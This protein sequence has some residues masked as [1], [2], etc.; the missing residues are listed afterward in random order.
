MDF[1]LFLLVNAALFIRPGELI[2]A[3]YGWPVYNFIIVANLLVAAPAVLNQL[4]G[5]NLVETPITVCVIGVFVCIVLSL[6]TMFDI[7]GAWNAGYEFSKVVAYFLLLLGTV[8]TPRRLFMLLAVIVACTVT[9]NVLAVL[10]YHEIYQLASIKNVKEGAESRMGATGIFGDPNDLSM[11]IVASILISTAGLFCKQLGLARILLVPPI[12]FLGYALTLTQSRGGLLAL[13]AGCGAAFYAK[14]GMLRASLLGVAVFPIL[15]AGFAGRQADISGALSGGTGRTRV[16]LWS[17]GLEML[18]SSPV[19]GVG[20]NHFTQYSSQVA[21]SSFVHAFAELGI[22]GGM[23]FLGIFILAGWS[24]WTLREVR[25]EILHPGLTYFLPF[26]VAVVVAYCVSM[27]SLS[28]SY[29]V[30]TYMV[31]GVAASYDR[32]A[33]PGTSL[34]PF[35]FSGQLLTWLA[36]CGAGFIIAT[37]LYIKFGFR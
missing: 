17:S 1:F 16:E 30:P 18:E 23:L 27:A 13:L 14:F 25:H 10:N 26:L 15:L 37:H 8:T 3:L 36:I 2:P 24:L 7:E 29:D 33:R 19:F 11:I 32:M 22:F 4:S 35:A 28:R 31:A 5:R 20:Y 12:G 9:I 34:P 21:H 6:L